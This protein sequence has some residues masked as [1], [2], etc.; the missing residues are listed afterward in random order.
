MTE[1][2]TYEAM[3]TYPLPETKAEATKRQRAGL[4]QPTFSFI[5]QRVITKGEDDGNI[6]AI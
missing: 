6:P 3:A 4:P 5:V 2:V 1:T